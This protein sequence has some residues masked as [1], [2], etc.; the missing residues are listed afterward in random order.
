M[1]ISETNFIERLDILEKIEDGFVFLC[2]RRTNRHAF[3]SQTVAKMLKDGASKHG[4]LIFERGISRSKAERAAKKIGATLEAFQRAVELDVF[5]EV[6][7]DL[8]RLIR[9]ECE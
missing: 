4:L 5:F 6:P 8:F 7:P 2:G 1:L 9:A 3:V